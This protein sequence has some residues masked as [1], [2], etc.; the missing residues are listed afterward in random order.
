[1][2]AYVC[3]DIVHANSSDLLDLDEETEELVEK[4]TELSSYFVRFACDALTY[5]RANPS[6][7]YHEN[8]IE[9]YSFALHILHVIIVIRESSLKT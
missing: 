9:A 8:I 7:P 2:S 4:I 5:T 3:P 1:M 6:S